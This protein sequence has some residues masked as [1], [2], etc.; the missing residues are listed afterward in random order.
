[1]SSSQAKLH[2]IKQVDG[3][4]PCIKC[5][6]TA[7]GW[8][9]A[10]EC[11]FPNWQSSNHLLQLS[12]SIDAKRVSGDSFVRQMDFHEHFKGESKTRQ[13]SLKAK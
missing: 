5:I 11:Q 1:M 9:S 12:D 8:I 2:S 4:S 13:L 10:R 7:V 6:H 3:C